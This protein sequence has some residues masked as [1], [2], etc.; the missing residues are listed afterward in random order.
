VRKRE[1]RFSTFFKQELLQAESRYA[2]ISERLGGDFHERV[3]ESIRVVIKRKGGDHVGP[4]GFP[5]RKCR[6]FPHLVYYQI[7][8]DTLYVLGVVHEGRH[9]D[10]LRRGLE[11]TSA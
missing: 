7:E 8:G 1:R 11:E 6:P 4:H 3:K 10:F 5:C 9:P 2:E